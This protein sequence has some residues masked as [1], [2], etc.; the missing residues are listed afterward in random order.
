MPFYNFK[1]TDSAQAQPNRPLIRL[2]AHGGGRDLTNWIFSIHSSFH[3]SQ[4]T[5]D[6]GKL[7]KTWKEEEDETEGS[8]MFSRCTLAS[9]DVPIA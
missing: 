4:Q 1:K 7:T 9:L 2:L 5:A 6:E 3:N 8:K